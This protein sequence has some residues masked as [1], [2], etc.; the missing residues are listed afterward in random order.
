[1]GV[2]LQQLCAVAPVMVVDV[3]AAV[4]VVMLPP[5]ALCCDWS[6]VLWLWHSGLYNWCCVGLC[7]P[8]EVGVQDPNG[9][10]AGTS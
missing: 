4:V 1:M 10:W 2:L 7:L 5:V 8:L 6:C 3:V 9:R